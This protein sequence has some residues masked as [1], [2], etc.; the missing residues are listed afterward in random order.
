V[1]VC[2][3]IT[4]GIEMQK[5]YFRSSMHKRSLSQVG[6]SQDRQPAKRAMHY[7]SLEPSL[8][9][10]SLQVHK[11]A[12]LVCIRDK[13]PKAKCHYLLVPVEKKLRSLGELSK[14]DLG[15]LE[16]MKRLSKVLIETKFDINDQSRY[17]IGF[18]SIQSMYPLHMHIL[19][20]DFQSDCLKTKK[21]WNSF[22]TK[23]FVHLN[24]ILGHLR[25][26]DDLTGL[27]ESDDKL[28]AHLKHDLVCNKCNERLQN[29][30]KLKQHLL[31]H[32]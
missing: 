9:D 30:P 11:D 13:Y 10:K 12:E 17:L 4:K 24:D 20:N 19:T 5:I 16:S 8:N 22:N 25:S 18:H 15:L 14:T 23:Y 6:A 31:K 29:M 27:V 7:M 1:R 32:K 21:H 26:N 3:N 28:E 2:T